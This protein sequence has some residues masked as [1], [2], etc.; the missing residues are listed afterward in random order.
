M[1][2]RNGQWYWHPNFILPFFMRAI[3]KGANSTVGLCLNIFYVCKIC[4]F[5]IHCNL[6]STWFSEKPE[7]TLCGWLGS[8]FYKPSINKYINKCLFVS[9]QPSAHCCGARERS[10]GEEADTVDDSGRTQGGPLQQT[11][12]GTG[13]PH[14][15][16]SSQSAVC[17]LIKLKLKNHLF[18]I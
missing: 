14:C 10:H 12:P 6:Y 2:D 15:S 1:P 3:T 11:A 5:W 13:Q 9:C 8:N 7:V 18:Y 17:P 16:V 4:M